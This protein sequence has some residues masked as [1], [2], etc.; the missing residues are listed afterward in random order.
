MGLQGFSLKKTGIGEVRSIAQWSSDHFELN[1][2]PLRIAV[3]QANWWFR[4]VTP[5]KEI[6]IQRQCRGSHPRE[7]RILERVCYLLRMNVQLIFVFDG[8]NKP[9]KRRP[10]ARTYSE[11]NLALLKE[12]LDQ[13]GVPRHEAPGEAEAECARL[14]KL[15]VV[16]AVWTDDTDTFMF[17][18]ETVV[19][20]CRLEGSEFNSEDSVLVYTADSLL[21]QSKL[22]QQGII[23][24]AI[25]VG[26]DY[27]DGLSRFGPRTLLELVKHHKFQET[28]EI[29]ATSA[30]NN[31]RELSK[32][33]AML[34]RMMKDTFPSKKFTLPP[35]NFPNL[36]VLG[37]CSCPNVSSDYKLKGLVRNWFRPFGPNLLAR[38]TFLLNHFHSRK[39]LY[40][41]VECLVPIELNHRLREKANDFNYG[42]TENTAIGSRKES[43]IVVDP[44]LVIPE[45]RDVYPPGYEFRKVEATL[46][47]C[48]IRRALPDLIEKTTKKKPRGRPQRI[49]PRGSTTTTPSHESRAR[50]ILTELQ[51]LDVVL[52]KR[53][54]SRKRDSSSFEG[55]SSNNPPE[56]SNTS[57]KKFH[58]LGGQTKQAE[59]S[60]YDAHDTRF[61]EASPVILNDQGGENKSPGDFEGPAVYKKHKVDMS[62]L[63]DITVIDLTEAD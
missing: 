55:G 19:Q 59:F 56:H 8:P 15:G 26:C 63:D 6:E 44:L 35:N 24:Y 4:N 43:T 28:A 32:W 11:D 34:F 13:L 33:R 39:S 22:T 18:C 30:S 61:L 29:L 31:H 10:T 50:E 7:K 52:N 54:R 41:P 53:G 49:P 23:M 14:Q 27:A 48:V 3:D 9:N 47:D 17:G 2:R 20:F 37:S 25:L 57:R 42:V 38:C 16:D 60:N 58:G 12:L 1:H 45:L 5:Q 36:E 40:W 51:S 21:S 62:S 46:L